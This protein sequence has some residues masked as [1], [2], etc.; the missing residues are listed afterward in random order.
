MEMNNCDVDEILKNKQGKFV[1]KKRKKEEQEAN[2]VDTTKL[3][4]QLTP[5]L[6]YK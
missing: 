5:T 1:R 4:R 6:V 3:K 2:T